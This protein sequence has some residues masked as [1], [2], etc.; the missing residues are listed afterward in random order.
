MSNSTYHSQFFFLFFSK[1]MW[2]CFIYY[3]NITL[4]MF[5]C[6][7]HFLHTVHAVLGIDFI[8][9]FSWLTI[10][11]T[12]VYIFFSDLLAMDPKSRFKAHSKHYEKWLLASSSLTLRL[13]VRME[14]LGSHWTNFCEI[15]YLSNFRKSV[16]KFDF[17]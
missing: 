15:L 5:H 4:G 3:T 1:N 17:H 14:Q 16:K 13:S 2:Q 8:L 11:P 12:Y 6:P 9:V 7:R 10:L